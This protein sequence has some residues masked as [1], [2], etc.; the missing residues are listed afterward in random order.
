LWSIKEENLSMNKK[1]MALAVAGAL[2]APAAALA[3]N[4][5]IYG[6]LTLGVDQYEAKGATAGSG[7]DY[8]KRS[9]VFDNGSRVGFRGTEDLGGGLQ[10]VFLIET[11]VSVDNGSTTGQ[12]AQNN[13]SAGNW[14]S[15]TGHVG[16]AG[17]WGMFT[18]GRSNVFWTNGAIEQVGAN[19]LNA[20]AQLYSG[21][22]GRGMSIGITRVSNTMQYTSPVFAGVNLVVSISPT[23]AEAVGPGANADSLGYGFTAQGTHGP[24]AWGF[25]WFTIDSNTPAAGGPPQSTT[26][27]TKVRAGFRYLPAGQ[28]SV[29]GL[30]TEVDKG[31]VTSTGASAGTTVGG[32]PATCN[33]AAAACD[34]NQTGY[35]L[36]WDHMFGPWHPIVQ[37]YIIDAIKGTGCNLN[38]ANGAALA[39]QPGIVGGQQCNL[40][41]ANQITVAL[42]Y[43][44]SKRTHAYISYNKIDNDVQYNQDFNGASMTSRNGAAN[45]FVGADPTIVAVGMIH[46]F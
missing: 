39:V 42:R 29:L 33:T 16:L 24:F 28:I 20:G 1:L 15:R 13:T 34:F 37:Y 18:Y 22:F 19:W 12:G 17:N 5:S 31:G 7:S 23:F 6:R 41:E 26:T 46:N 30:K 8:T 21:T 43:I 9:R 3:Q 25:D 27:G 40:T 45:Q 38:G 11:G 35:G 44:F 14:G 32:L 2:G 36:S 10:A 4:Y